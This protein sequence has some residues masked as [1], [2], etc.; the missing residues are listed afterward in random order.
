MN[1]IEGQG[2]ES[3]QSDRTID[4]YERILR[5]KVEHHAND[6]KRKFR[7]ISDGDIPRAA[8]QHLIASIFGTQHQISPQQIDQLIQRLHLKHLD[9]IRFDEEYLYSWLHEHLNFE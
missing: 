2:K 5:E 9:K 6:V 8:L 1:Q 3:E 7:Q 4:E